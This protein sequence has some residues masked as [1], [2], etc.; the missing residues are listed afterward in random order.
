MPC[1]D[2]GVTSP[3]GTPTQDPYGI[4]DRRKYL[5]FVQTAIARMSTA[6]NTSKGW[7]LTVATA[8]LGY[9]LTNDSPPVAL[10]GVGAIAMFAFLD[11]RY[12]REE[13]KFRELYEDAR[14]HR[15]D[16]YDMRAARYADRNDPQHHKDR[17]DW[18]S[19]AKSWSLWGFYGPMLAVAIAVAGS[20][21][22][23]GS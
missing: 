19:I 3:G 21:S 10:L 14:T 20:A 7:S 5:E 4:E 12:L 9:A 18:S 8:V 13:R 15:S 17:C 11:A 22:L 6:S 23:I 16:F 1:D 2:L